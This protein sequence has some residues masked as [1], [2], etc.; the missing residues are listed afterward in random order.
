SWIVATNSGVTGSGSVLDARKAVISS[1]WLAFS[2]S[3]LAWMM[4]SSRLSSRVCCQPSS[5]RSSSSSRALSTLAAGSR[6]ACSLAGRKPQCGHTGLVAS[7]ASTSEAQLL[8]LSSLSSKLVSCPVG[9]NEI[10]ASARSVVMRESRRRAVLVL[11]S[12][13]P[14]RALLCHIGVEVVLLERSQL[15]AVGGGQGCALVL[16]EFV[17]NVLAG[18]LR[19]LHP[20]VIARQ[21]HFRLGQ[22]ASHATQLGDQ[23]TQFFNGR[24]HV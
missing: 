11:S 15:L 12:A 7:S 23:I 4:G 20:G 22:V 10:P 6:S 21:D 9:I 1:R 5:R 13:T 3:K 2:N 19:L 14:R 24:E 8:S 18:C 16:G 17:E